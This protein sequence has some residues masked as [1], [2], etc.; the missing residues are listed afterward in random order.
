MDEISKSLLRNIPSE[1]RQHIHSYLVPSKDTVIK[2]GMED[3][4]TY[5]QTFRGLLESS[6]S[7]FQEL[8]HFCYEHATF[9][10]SIS[11]LDKICP[12]HGRAVGRFASLLGR[13]RKVVLKLY[14]H[15]EAWCVIPL[16]LPKIEQQKQQCRL[17]VD[18][19]SQTK[20][21]NNTLLLDSL[22]VSMID[23]VEDVDWHNPG[24]AIEREKS[25]YLDAFDS[26]KA[27][28]GSFEIEHHIITDESIGM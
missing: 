21:S 5:R 7:F 28:V 12:S 19:L 9:S 20:K 4:Y 15:T 27:R 22:T 1:L 8:H 23:Y 26:I 6:R 10:L 13:V 24:S 14:I 2:I 25:T 16:I 11:W 3:F 18:I 17:F